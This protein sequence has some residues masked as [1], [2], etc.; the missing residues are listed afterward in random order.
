MIFLWNI[1]ITIPLIT[2]C[3]G[4]KYKRLWEIVQEVV[5]VICNNFHCSHTK[6]DSKFN[7]GWPLTPCVTN[8]ILKIVLKL[9]IF[10]QS[11]WGL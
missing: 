4:I 1:P 8:E 5:L 3:F 7:I 9:L 10:S 11:D 2:G 6:W